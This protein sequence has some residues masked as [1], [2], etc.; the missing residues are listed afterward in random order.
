MRLFAFLKSIPTLAKA[1]VKKSSLIQNLRDMSCKFLGVYN[2][3][4][5]RAE[6]EGEN[7]GF[8]GRELFSPQ[9]NLHMTL[10]TLGYL[11]YKKV[12]E[13][14]TSMARKRDKTLD[15]LSVKMIMNGKKEMYEKLNSL[16]RGK[17]EFLIQTWDFAYCTHPNDAGTQYLKLLANANQEQEAREN[18]KNKSKQLFSL[19]NVNTVET[20]E[21]YY[22]VETDDG[23]I[24]EVVI[25]RFNS[26]FKKGNFKRK[27]FISRK[28]NQGK[29][30]IPPQNRIIFRNLVRKISMTARTEKVIRVKISKP[31]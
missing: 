14:L 12:E 3:L 2:D 11:D 4:I 10:G 1:G 21:D 9:L 5:N 22:E 17:S 18:F 19:E 23:T 25:N 16:S 13:I 30:P 31:E 15:E 20:E 8:I 26:K 29:F 6:I 24:N 28:P 27:V 7:F